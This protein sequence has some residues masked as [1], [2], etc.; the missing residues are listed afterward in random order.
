MFTLE[1]GN[2]IELMA[3]VHILGQMVRYFFVIKS[4]CKR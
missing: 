4:F 1:I 2:K 3:M